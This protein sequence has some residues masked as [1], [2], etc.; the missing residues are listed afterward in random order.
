MLVAIAFA[1]ANPAAAS[2]APLSDVALYHRCFV[3]LTGQYPD[4]MSD[5]GLAQVRSGQTTAI[6]ACLALLD[7]AA[8][9]PQGDQGFLVDDDALGRSV[10]ATFH[11]LHGSWFLNRTFPEF[12]DIILGTLSLYDPSEPASY[13]TRALFQPDV[14][15]SSIWTANAHLRVA[16]VSSGEPL[17]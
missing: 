8:L 14:S 6:D 10:L 15:A 3:R 5:V 7:R 4:Y 9:R 12:D 16:R 17:V 1:V 2:A 11:A 13:I